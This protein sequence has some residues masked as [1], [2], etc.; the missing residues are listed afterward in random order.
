MLIS[1]NNRCDSQKFSKRRW[2]HARA[3]S[4]NLRFHPLLC[5]AFWLIYIP[6]L[7]NHVL[8]CSFNVRFARQVWCT[9]THDGHRLNLTCHA[10]GCFIVLVDQVVLSNDVLC[11]LF[12][13]FRLYTFV[14][15]YGH[16]NGRN[17]MICFEKRTRDYTRNAC[18]VLQ[19]KRPLW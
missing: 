15:A 9:W 14:S 18:D 5:W 2:A 10:L 16:K 8:W 13:L 12:T 4:F 7:Y 17:C 19:F 1:S 3:L 6:S 11:A